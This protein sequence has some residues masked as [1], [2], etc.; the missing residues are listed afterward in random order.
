MPKIETRESI[1]A[2]F[3]ADPRA[4]FLAILTAI[5][6]EV[7]E[8][9][10]ELVQAESLIGD[11]AQ[12]RKMGVPERMRRVGVSEELVAQYERLLRWL[13]AVAAG[14]PIPADVLHAAEEYLALQTDA[15]EQLAKITEGSKRKM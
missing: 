14:G 15:A 8:L 5:K 3:K 12:W 6:Q 1:E 7:K 9:D 11:P 13:V 10:T 2:E 4:K